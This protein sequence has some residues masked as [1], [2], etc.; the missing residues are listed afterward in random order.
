MSCTHDPPAGGTCVP[1]VGEVR[2]ETLGGKPGGSSP[3]S[4]SF[5]IPFNEEVTVPGPEEALGEYLWNEC[6]KVWINE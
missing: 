2:R 5:L 1:G 4:A 3:P 6:I